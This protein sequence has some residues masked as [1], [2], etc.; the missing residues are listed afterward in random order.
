[1]S[2]LIVSGICQGWSSKT[3]VAIIATTFALAMA[4]FD[5]LLHFLQTPSLLP[6]DYHL[7]FTIAAIKSNTFMPFLPIIAV[8]PFAG[9]YV[10]EIKSKFVR[11][12]I[13][14]TGYSSYLICRAIV[15]FILGGTVIVTG[16]LI[17]YFCNALLFLPME[18]TI[19]QEI[20]IENDFLARCILL[21]LIG[22]LWAVAGITT[23][24]L[25]ESKYIAYASPFVIYYMLVILYER[26]FPQAWLL[27]P[28]HWLDLSREWPLGWV[29]S[30]IWL[31]ELTSVMA[32]YFVIRGRRRL[33]DL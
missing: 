13:F 16:T 26:Y 4:S 1:M 18:T 15:S 22:G 3:V 11:F 19:E 5:T 31:S 12:Y 17:F 33:M 25:M 7:D 29:G 27:Y 28:N 14:R 24:T 23:S 6:H 9:T 30:A 10:D 20:T 32:I 2:T 8:L 21:F